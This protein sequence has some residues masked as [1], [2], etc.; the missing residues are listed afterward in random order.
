MPITTKEIHFN[1]AYSH[2][3][4]ACEFSKA[5]IM[6]QQFTFRAVSRAIP[7]TG[8]I[9]P[10]QNSNAFGLSV[11]RQFRDFIITD[12][13]VPIGIYQ[14]IF[15]IHISGI[16]NESFLHFK[17]CGIIFKQ[18]PAPRRATRFDIVNLFQSSRFG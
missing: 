17:N 11:S 13:P 18:H 12:F 5:I 3:F 7:V 16:I 14:T 1:P 4:E 10:E 9:I 2:L 15:P 8:R 6:S